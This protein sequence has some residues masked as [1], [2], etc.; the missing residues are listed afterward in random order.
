MKIGMHRFYLF[1]L[2]FTVCSRANHGHWGKGNMW[3][4]NCTERQPVRA[5]GMVVPWLLS[6]ADEAVWL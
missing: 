2:L 5:K 4:G 6:A 3:Q 1:I